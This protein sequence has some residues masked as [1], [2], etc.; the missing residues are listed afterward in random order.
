MPA[1]TSGPSAEVVVVQHQV[2]VLGKHAQLV[3]QGCQH[4]LDGR[5]AGLELVERCGRRPGGGAVDGVQDVGPEQGGVTV[6][7]VERDPRRRP[8]GRPPSR[9]RAGSSCRTRR[10]RDQR[11]VRVAPRPAG[12]RAGDGR[13]GHARMRG[14][15][16]LVFTTGTLIGSAGQS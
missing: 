4:G 5:L 6:L 1:W 16:S 11:Q 2:E 10:R 14:R 7:L 15:A 12:R 13:R 9:C 8:A 3:E